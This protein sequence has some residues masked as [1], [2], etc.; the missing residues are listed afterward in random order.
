MLHVLIRFH[1]LEA[2]VRAD[3]L[4]QTMRPLVAKWW[5]LVEAV[6]LLL[7]LLYFYTTV[8]CPLPSCAHLLALTKHHSEWLV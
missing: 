2:L 7:L 8:S 4:S 3:S 6:M 1:L 5:L